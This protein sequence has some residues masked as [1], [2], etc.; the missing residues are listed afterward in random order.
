MDAVCVLVCVTLKWAR[1]FL[2]A[3]RQNQREAL[4]P[5][6]SFSVVNALSLATPQKP[7]ADSGSSSGG[8][9]NHKE[10]NRSEV[11]MVFFFS[12]CG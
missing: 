3:K 9:E 7:L 8:V 6:Y 1:L 2:G 5:V 10:T 12:C 11:T 4:F